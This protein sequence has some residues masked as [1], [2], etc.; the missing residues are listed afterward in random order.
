MDS[1]QTHGGKTVSFMKAQGRQ[2]ERRGGKSKIEKR[3]CKQRWR[4][5]WMTLR[6]AELLGKV[7]GWHSSERWRSCHK[8]DEVNMLKPE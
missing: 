5:T 4:H 3:E 1:K 8:K 7:D 6:K 2:R